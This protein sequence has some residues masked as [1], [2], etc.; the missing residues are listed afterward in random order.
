MLATIAA[1][2]LLPENAS[3][4]VRLEAL[5]HCAASLKLNQGPNISSGKLRE[6][7]QHSALESM[8][9]LE[10]PAENP[11]AVEFT[12]FGG[13]HLVLPGVTQDAEFILSNLCKAIFLSDRE[14][15]PHD[16]R[17]RAFQIVSAA[18]RLSN[19]I[20]E[21]AGIR[22]GIAPSS[23]RFE[24][25]FIPNAETLRRLK[26]AVTFTSDEVAGLLE[27]VGLPIDSLA[28]LTC[29]AGMTSVDQFSPDNGPLLWNPL[30][31]C[32]G[33]IISVI[34]AMLISAA[35]HAVLRLAYSANL[36]A[37]IVEAYNKATWHSV[38]R[39][40]S[41]TSN[42]PILADVLEPTKLPNAVDGYFTLDTDK[43]LYCLLVTDGLKP[44]A[45]SDPFGT[46]SDNRLNEFVSERI[47][48]AERRAFSFGDAPNELLKLAIFQ[49]VGG[50]CAFGFTESSPSP[51]LGISAAALRTIC[52]VERG[53]SLALLNFARARDRASKQFRLTT[54][55]ALDE[56][57]LYRKNEHSYYFSDDKRP[58]TILIMPGDSLHLQMEIEQKNDFH[59]AKMA[60]GSVL[61]VQS[62][63]ET[64]AIPIYRPVSG[65]WGRV[66]FLVEGLQPKVWVVGPGQTLAAEDHKM[67]RLFAETVSFWI[68]QFR[69]L[70]IPALSKLNAN[71]PIEIILDLPSHE[72][73]K[74]PDNFTTE[75]RADS[76]IGTIVDKSRRCIQ[77][78]I[79]AGFFP[80]FSRPDNF[81]ER[82]LM[83]HILNAF[84]ELSPDQSTRL[85]PADMINKAMEQ[86]APLGSK[87]MLVLFDPGRMPEMDDR[88]LPPYRPLQKVWVSSNLDEIGQYLAQDLGIDVGDISLERRV[89][90][91]NRIANHCFCKLDAILKTISPR[92]LLGFVVANTEAVHHEQAMIR[93]NIA[94]RLECFRTI[95][96]MI[97]E[98]V[99]K[100]PQLANVGLASRFIV[101]SS[102]R[103]RRPD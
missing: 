40:L 88:G 10:D 16:F 14:K 76:S 94:P 22:R 52:I 25:I 65:F 46:W 96:E 82:E 71:Q 79:A 58:T 5:S 8:A 75:S 20:A 101:R 93:L 11:F 4:S 59:G 67:N 64:T 19:A 30:V 17:C 2:H 9:H 39:S 28:P 83:R 66:R 89:N 26:A 33:Q 6:I 37:E 31:E 103:S 78:S 38:I 86:T 102:P 7:C 3:R 47:A 29:E 99:E 69:S 42:L 15:F 24:P 61:E 98:L 90:V 45:L 54:T 35:R 34:P 68:W 84:D 72:R 57:Y 85:L 50:S 70:L 55:N 44:G 36:Q 27:S 48:E 43:M 74:F 92:G 73:W 63:Y 51:F 32:S 87:K 100:T 80:G 81:G 91:L 41:L 13:S 60:D 21:K 95:P 62:F 77:V 49:G 23:D 56:F 12:F 97:N 18:L 1:L 53:D